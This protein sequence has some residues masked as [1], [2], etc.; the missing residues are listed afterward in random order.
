MNHQVATARRIAFSVEYDGTAYHGWQAQRSGCPT[1]Q[2]HLETAFSNLLSRECPV[3]GASRTDAGVH[4]RDQLAAVTIDHPIEPDGLM[5][6]V[7]QRLP[8]D[9]AIR[10]PHLVPLSYNPRFG[11]VQKTYVYRMYRD[12]HRQPLIDRYAWRLPWLLDHDAMNEAAR[13]CI[14]T[15]DFTSFAAADGSHKTTERTIHHLQVSRPESNHT[16]ITVQ[17][18]AFMKNMVRI[19]VGTLVDIGRGHLGQGT[20]REILDAR[21][22]QAAGPTAPAHGLVLSR[23]IANFEESGL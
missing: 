4:A 3:Q 5:K 2:G 8:K 1:I 13:T 11:N 23:I 15:Q 16:V 19:I 7:N 10:N 18:T 20:M 6:A 21:N 12:H 14:G 9:I 22:R 17:G